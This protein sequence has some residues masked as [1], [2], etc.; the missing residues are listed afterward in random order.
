MWC[1]M[2]LQVEDLGVYMQYF[3]VLL[4][5]LSVSSNYEK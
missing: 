5:C 3:V 1:H 2:E 4:H